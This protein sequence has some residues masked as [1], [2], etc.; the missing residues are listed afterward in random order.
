MTI[1]LLRLLLSFCFDWEDISTIWD[2]VSSAIQTPPVLSKILLCAS[3]FQLSSQC[4]DIPIKHCFS[5]L[6]YYM[7]RVR[8]LT[9][10]DCLQR[11]VPCN[12]YTRVIIAVYPARQRLPSR[13]VRW[14]TRGRN[15]KSTKFSLV[16]PPNLLWTLIPHTSSLLC[17]DLYWCFLQVCTSQTNYK[18]S[19]EKTNLFSFAADWGAVLFAK[20]TLIQFVITK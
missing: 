18:T 10:R 19:Q 13:F 11:L 6:M 14:E 16:C 7:S 8:S 17:D 15:R 2:S 3:Y 5:R 20:L 1:L 12:I 9:R 4:L